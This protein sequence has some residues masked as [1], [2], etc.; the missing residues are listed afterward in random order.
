M[1]II[2]FSRYINSIPYSLN[3]FASIN[4]YRLCEALL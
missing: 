1:M 4:V 3:M 2:V